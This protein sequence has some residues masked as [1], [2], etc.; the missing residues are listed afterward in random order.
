MLT[1]A[2]ENS[3]VL[4][5][6][7]DTSAGQRK[8]NSPSKNATRGRSNG[9]SSAAAEIEDAAG[10][11]A[12]T[13]EAVRHAV[14]RDQDKRTK[15]GPT[16]FDFLHHAQK[17]SGRRPMELVREFF[18]LSRGCGKLTLPEY[19]QYGLYD[20]SRYSPEDQAR[21]LAYDLHW[22]ITHACCDMTWQA[23]TEDKWL[24]SHILD[25]SAIRVPKTLA[26]IDKTERSYPNTHK[27]ST[28]EQLRDFMTSQD[29][30]PL[31]GKENRGICSLGAF[32]VV[33]ANE[34]AMCLKGDGW[35]RYDACMD[36]F[37]GATPYLLQALEHNH[38]FF[39]RY[40]ESLATVRVCIL[41]AE[42]GI[43]I[44]FAVLKL[45]SRDNVADSFWRPG[46][47]ACNLDLQSGKILTARTRDSFG[48]TD[49]T[50]HPETGEPLL[51]ET[52]PMWDRLLE[53]VLS[54]AP[55]FRPVRYQ[56]M[57]IAITEQGPVLIEINTGGGFD[58]PQFASGEGFLT[59][60]VRDF[61]RSCGYKKL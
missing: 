32:L 11:D 24:C 61:F 6:V 21:F 53:L 40:T 49:H 45:P 42:T 43:K 30:L 22:P 27:I 2:K 23:T 34:D 17:K 47:L 58:L 54:C 56:S 38:S 50:V 18:R 33:D 25:R 51:G 44:P 29:A 48:T 46:N 10:E 15:S 55:I 28:T 37:L 5:S 13:D 41:I 14:T 7:S 4:E 19:V 60:D 26:V 35:I 3:K 12:S 16:V 1:E 59:D 39:L 20:K 57:D 31:F 9:D 52:V 36:Q 8:P